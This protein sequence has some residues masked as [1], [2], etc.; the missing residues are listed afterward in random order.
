MDAEP[1]RVCK[2]I[3]T[4]SGILNLVLETQYVNEVFERNAAK[5][6]EEKDASKT[7]RV[8]MMDAR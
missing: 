5:P 1:A 4:K 7:L 6:V 2:L 3:R 8:L